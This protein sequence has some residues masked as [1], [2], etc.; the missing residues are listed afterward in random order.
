MSHQISEIVV[1]GG[2]HGNERTGVAALQIIQNSLSQYAYSS[3]KNI[4]PILANPKAILKNTRYVNAD[5]NRQFQYSYINRKNFEY[6]MREAKDSNIYEKYRALEIRQEIGA[7]EK[8]HPFVL[9]FHTTTANT[10]TCLII[11]NQDVWTRN[12]C[13]YIY[14][15]IPEITLFCE[16]VPPEEDLTSSSLGARS[17]TLEIGPVMQGVV[18]EEP[19]KKMLQVF[20]K[21]C[22]GI[23]LLNQTTTLPQDTPLFQKNKVVHVSGQVDYPRDEM[24]IPVAYIHPDFMHSDFQPLKL[25]QPIFKTLIGNTLFLK[26][27]IDSCLP[28]K[29]QLEQGKEVVPI[30][31]GESAYLE[32][33]IAFIFAVKEA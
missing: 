7:L 1:L 20:E 17:L 18:L 15:N 24:G 26:D 11:P 8:P 13:E 6:L 12:L 22:E 10:K 4:L 33:R 32:K 9:D 23:H 14:K 3:I 16:T 28:L 29:S 5:L 25:E 21:I 27:I 30:F 31:I 19:L 2:T